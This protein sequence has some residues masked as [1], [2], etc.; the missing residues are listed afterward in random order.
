M[1]KKLITVLQNVLNDNYA[2]VEKD[3]SLITKSLNDFI[4]FQ[5]LYIKFE[6]DKFQQ[7]KNFLHQDKDFDIKLT[8]IFEQS[9]KESTKSYSVLSNTLP[10]EIFVVKG[11]K[12][13]NA[14]QQMKKIHEIMDEDFS[15]FSLL[16]NEYYDDEYEDTSPLAHKLLSFNLKNIPTDLKESLI[17]YLFRSEGPMEWS[18]DSSARIEAIKSLL[19]LYTSPKVLEIYNDVVKSTNKAKEISNNVESVINSITEMT[20]HPE[21]IFT[22]KQQQFMLDTLANI[23]SIFKINIKNENV[24]NVED[25]NYRRPAEEMAIPV[26]PAKTR[27]KIQDNIDNFKKQIGTYLL[28]KPNKPKI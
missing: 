16:G 20:V 18:I 4:E 24:W 27:Q 26:T 11:G 17:H 14:L 15:G 12:S 23:V 9:I 21:K 25:F 28:V 3:C 19:P 8:K 1:D 2:N 22:P 13:E 6:N 7:L 10:L 5:T